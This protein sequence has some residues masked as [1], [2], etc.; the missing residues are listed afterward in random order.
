MPIVAPAHGGRLL[1]PCQGGGQAEAGVEERTLE[2][3]PD[4]SQSQSMADVGCRPWPADRGH[5]SECL[6]KKHFKRAGIQ[7]VVLDAAPLLPVL[8]AAHVRNAV[9]GVCYQ[10]VD[11]LTSTRRCTSSGRVASPQSK[12]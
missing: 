9:R 7:I 11:L 10:T 8:A 2:G 6:S 1:D 5:V 12:R 3:N 4:A